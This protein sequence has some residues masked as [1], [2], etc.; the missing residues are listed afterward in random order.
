MEAAGELSLP[1]E[2]DDVKEKITRVSSKN[3]HKF[4]DLTDWQALR[5]MTDDD[6]ERAAAS[7][8]DAP[9][10]T[11][12][13]WATARLVFPPGKTPIEVGI[14]RDIASWFGRSAHDFRTR[15]NAVLRDYIEAQ[16]Q[17]QKPPTASKIAR[18]KPRRKTPARAAV[19]S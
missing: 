5:A 7:D 14:D 19:K 12:E 10:M 1:E 15:I 17:S 4:K 13:D 16:E 2:Q 18:P 6:I 3:L 9:P 8:P 11:E